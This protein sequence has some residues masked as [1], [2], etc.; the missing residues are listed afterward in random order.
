[1]PG[2]HHFFCAEWRRL[3]KVVVIEDE[4]L[5]DLVAGAP[6][7][8]E[9]VLDAGYEF[10]KQNGLQG[11][12][13]EVDQDLFNH[14]NELDGQAAERGD[15]SPSGPRGRST[16]S[17]E[18][19]K[20]LGRGRSMSPRSGSPLSRCATRRLQG[21]RPASP[22]RVV[23]RTPTPS[24]RSPLQ[25]VATSTTNLVIGASATSSGG[26]SRPMLFV[27]EKHPLAH[28]P[29]PVSREDFVAELC[30]RLRVPRLF[31]KEA[32]EHKERAGG[33]GLGQG[34]PMLTSEECEDL[35][36]ILMQMQKVAGAAHANPGS[37]SFGYSM[38]ATVDSF[39]G[40]CSLR[41]AMERGAPSLNAFLSSLEVQET[42]L[43][44]HT[45]MRQFLAQ[46]SHRLAVDGL[47]GAVPVELIV[48]AHSGID[49]PELRRRLALA[50]PVGASLLEFTGHFEVKHGYGRFKLPH[51]SE[52][53]PLWIHCSSQEHLD[54][55]PQDVARFFRICGGSPHVPL[56][57]DALDEALKHLPLEAHWGTEPL[58]VDRLFCALG[59][60]CLQLERTKRKDACLPPEAVLEIVRKDTSDLE[61]AENVMISEGVLKDRFDLIWN[62]CVREGLMLALPPDSDHTPGHEKERAEQAERRKEKEEQGTRR[63][64]QACL[65]RFVAVGQELSRQVTRRQYEALFPNIS[66]VLSV[67]S[68]TLRSGQVVVVR[69]RLAGA[70]RLLKG[71]VFG[72]PATSGIRSIECSATS[73]SPFPG[74]CHRRQSFTCQGGLLQSLSW[75]YRHSC[76][77]PITGKSF[78]TCRRLILPCSRAEVTRFAVMTAMLLGLQVLVDLPPGLRRRVF[79]AASAKDIFV[80]DAQKTIRIR[81]ARL[82]LLQYALWA[83]RWLKAA[84]VALIASPDHVQTVYIVVWQLLRGNSYLKYRSP[85]VT[86]RMTLQQPT[87]GSQDNFRKVS[88]L[89]YCCRD[90]CQ[91]KADNSSCTCPGRSYTNYWCLYVD[92]AGG[93]QTYPDNIVINTFRH[94][95][96]Q[97]RNASCGQDGCTKL[98]VTSGT[99]SRFMA[100]I[101]DFTVLIAHAVQNEE[102]GITKTSEMAGW[103]LVN[104]TS[105]LQNQL[106]N[107]T[108]TS[109]TQPWKGSR[110]DKAPCYIKPNSTAKDGLDYFTVGTLMMAMGLSLDGS[111]YHGSGHSLRYEG[112]TV[113]LKIKYFDTW[114]WHGVLLCPVC[115]ELL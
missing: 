61:K 47:P 19:T 13:M 70:S 106:C 30:R 93:T 5:F 43:V 68:T 24:L 33:A 113:T 11:W 58:A 31:N 87:L 32:K 74:P 12:R 35:F 1:M 22:T 55:S 101:E 3:R 89:S 78:N 15:A 53:V 69:Y 79:S 46:V 83:W 20:S 98:W 65:A 77:A 66:D 76:K 6:S 4:L 27:N 26:P 115:T 51:V 2:H 50:A 25:R 100:D 56:Q 29:D 45:L 94:E 108:N 21:G 60:R 97:E 96:I 18:P 109:M 105:E 49:V 57:P 86:T 54:I 84:C 28:L 63:M 104:G 40:L 14:I 8:E 44:D 112:L 10:A 71:I 59:R 91:F 36:D 99:E 48:K 42:K 90:G 114:P 107:S 73:G 103:L 34:E 102:L 67:S 92:G 64:K 80:Y 52:F 37:L 38:D 88:D 9:V 95:Y 39:L 7:P 62:S 17:R 75:P 81:D 23:T 110:T 41:K 16:V 82:G 111:S 72:R 85:V